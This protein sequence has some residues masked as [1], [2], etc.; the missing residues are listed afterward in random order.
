MK[1]L[2]N[3]FR[4]KMTL[5]GVPIERAAGSSPVIRYVNMIL[6]G[7]FKN[8]IGS[9]ILRQSEYL[10]P[11]AELGEQLQPPPL[12][13]A[14]NRL[15]IMAGLNPGIY[16]KPVEGAIQLTIGGTDCRVLCRFDDSTDDRCDITME[17][18]QTAQPPAAG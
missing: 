17:K 3:L 8:D 12:D 16:S 10:P 11:I 1:V 6:Y 9:R 5:N 4:R 18:E 15:K 13:A 14:I 7:M 2:R